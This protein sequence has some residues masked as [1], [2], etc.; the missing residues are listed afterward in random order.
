MD[1]ISAALPNIGAARLALG[2]P[3]PRCQG[4]QAPLCG[5]PGLCTRA[6]HCVCSMAAGV[7]R[8]REGEAAA[9]LAGEGDSAKQQRLLQELLNEQ[10]QLHMP[11]G[12]AAPQ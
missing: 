12:V 8:E 7:K 2:P 9:A 6:W 4:L 11:S 10:M 3:R 5:W 1:A